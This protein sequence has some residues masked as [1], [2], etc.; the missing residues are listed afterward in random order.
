LKS[1]NPA[2]RI[3]PKPRLYLELST[4]KIQKRIDRLND[5]S[6]NQTRYQSD[7]FPNLNIQI[8]KPLKNIKEILDKIGT[9]NG[10]KNTN[11]I[12]SNK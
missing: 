5:T 3:K 2:T 10:N 8:I 11:Q 1:I 12:D 6:I 9:Q 4:D 7:V